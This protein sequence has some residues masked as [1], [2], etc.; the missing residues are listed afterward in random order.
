MAR[1]AAINPE[2]L[3][4]IMAA[5]RSGTPTARSAVTAPRG[6]A[7]R[8][9]GM[10][11]GR[12]LPADANAATPPAPNIAPSNQQGQPLVRVATPTEAARL[13]SGTHFIDPAGKE[14]VVP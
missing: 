14:R 1:A 13:P 8:F 2:V 9:A 12:M 7:D 10:Q 5:R 3:K 4:A 6:A 11:P